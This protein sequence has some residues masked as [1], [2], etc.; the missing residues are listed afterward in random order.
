MPL[1]DSQRIYVSEVVKGMRNFDNTNG[2]NYELAT[3][4]LTNANNADAGD[5]TTP[6]V[7]PIGIPVIYDSANDQWVIFN[8]SDAGIAAAITADDSTLPNRAPIAIVVGNEFGFGFNPNNITLDADGEDVTV[9][10][11]GTGEVA[12]VRDSIKWTAGGVT[13][14]TAN[15]DAFVEQL[16]KQGIAVITNATVVVPQFES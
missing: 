13:T 14:S 3:I 9:L 4:T 15:Q 6:S 2:F 16:E 5:I 1:N 12:V 10:Y 8:D 11:R 7:E